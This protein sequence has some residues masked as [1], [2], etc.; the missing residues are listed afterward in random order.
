M[1]TEESFSIKR[2]FQGQEQLVMALILEHGEL[3]RE[4]SQHGILPRVYHILMVD[5]GS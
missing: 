2:S 4:K 3:S 5:I 1:M